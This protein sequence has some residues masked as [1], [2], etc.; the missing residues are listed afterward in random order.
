[1]EMVWTTNMNTW[2]KRCKGGGG[3]GASCFKEVW[4]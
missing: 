3:G 2:Y 1:M 4:H